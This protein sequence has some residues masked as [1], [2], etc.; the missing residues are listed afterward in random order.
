MSR[1]LLR[2]SRLGRLMVLYRATHNFGVRDLAKQS[3]IS[4]AT[5]SRIERGH[6]MD[7]ATLLRLWH[8]LLLPEEKS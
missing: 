6:A 8:W 5:I 7:A 4:I 3:G 1:T 2:K